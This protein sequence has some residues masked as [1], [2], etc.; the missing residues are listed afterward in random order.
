MRLYDPGL[1]SFW[2][3]NTPEDL[4]LAQKMAIEIDRQRNNFEDQEDD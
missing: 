3:V 1:V 4:S 2:N